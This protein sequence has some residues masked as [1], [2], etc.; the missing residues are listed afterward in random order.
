MCLSC[1][2]LA[3]VLRGRGEA[4]RRPCCLSPVPAAASPCS[5][6]DC[7][8][9]DGQRGICSRSRRHVLV[10]CAGLDTTAGSVM[11]SRAAARVA[12]I[13]VRGSRPCGPRRGGAAD[14]SSGL[15]NPAT[16]AIAPPQIPSLSA[17]DRTVACE[18]L[19]DG[20]CAAA[21]SDDGWQRDAVARP[22]PRG[23][24]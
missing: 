13:L 20:R 12:G 21:G 15:P 10:R 9:A 19:K 17:G 24:F 3:P 11:P 23:A 18:S 16:P 22:W 8:P 4:N 7:A 6:S 14:R 1:P 5:A 2:F